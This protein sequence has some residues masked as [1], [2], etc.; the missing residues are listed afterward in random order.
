MSTLLAAVLGSPA[1]AETPAPA[2]TGTIPSGPPA[3]STT[4][5]P[6]PVISTAAAP[7]SAAPV[8]RPW[9]LGDIAVSGSQ[10]VKPRVVIAQTKARKGDLYDRPDLDRDVQSILGLGN[11]ER[12]AADIS[13]MD[14]PVPAQWRKVAG[15]DKMV[16]LTFLVK[17][18]PIV[19]KIKFSGNK[20]LSKGA[21]EDVLTLKAKDPVDEIKLRDDQEKLLTKYHEKGFL[22]ASVLYAL[23]KDTATLQTTVQWTITEGAKSHI[24]RVTIAGTTVLKPKALAKLMKNRAKGWFRAGVYSA[25]DLP[26]D[27]KTIEDHYTSRGFLDVSVTTPAVSVS[28]DKTQI[29]IDMS[30]S[31]GRSYKFGDTSF[32]GNTVLVST[33]LAKALEYRRGLI[34]NQQKFDESIRSIQELYADQ[35]RLRARVAP[36]KNFNAKTDLMDVALTITEGDIVTIEHVDVEGNKAT[37]THVLRREVTVK[38]GQVFSLAR[39]RKSRERIM[40]LGFID[41]VDVDIQPTPDPDKVDIGFDVTEGKPGVMSAG[42][43]YSS[44][45]GLIGTLS[46]QHMNLFG[47]AQRASLQWSFGKRVQ[48]YSASWT[49]PWL[50]DSPTSFGLDAFNTRRISPY[51]SSLNAYT[52]KRTGATVRLGPRF[53]EDKYHLN[54]AYTISQMSVQN[55]QN[56]FLG[57]LSPGTSLY[58]SFSA[59]FA[60]DTRD[61]IYDPTHGTRHAIGA[62]LTGGPLMGQ[63][64]FFKPSISNAAYFTPTTIGDEDWPVVLGFANRAAYVTPFGATKEVPVFERFFVG[65]QDTLRGYNP[66]GEA[67]YPQGGKVYDIANIE[68]GVPLARE[69]KKSIVKFVTFFDIGSSWDRTKDV[70]LRVGTGVRDLKT[71]AGFGIRFVTP[72][73]P[74]RL[75]WGYGFNHRPGE[76]LYQINFGMGNL[77]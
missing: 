71:D 24:E 25:K 27:V 49:T 35:G 1:F 23:E 77:F 44:I 70:S 43:A 33:A 52:Q 56:E 66:T 65:G 30:V 58:S 37:K 51:A 32:A 68:L 3:I 50:G 42:A 39:L 26:A 21:L 59:E 22:D 53:E 6:A 62:S 46:L 11:F 36:S 48:D 55:V 8:P 60:R 29:F 61:N 67:G 54:L 31:E 40:N 5:L 9:V 75:D 17:E 20:K 7:A 63:I 73:F 57:T 38:P 13:V 69:H 64:N 45:D 4:T 76:K 16:R 14:K 19:K 72:A 28:T 12:V 41:D 2:S 34:F 18:K 74:I 15:A 47:R 10:N